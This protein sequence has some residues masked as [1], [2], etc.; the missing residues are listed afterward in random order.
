MRQYLIVPILVVMLLFAGCALPGSGNTQTPGQGCPSTNAPVCGS[1]GQTYTNSCLAQSAGVTVVHDGVCTAPNSAACSDG[2]G[3]K[4]IFTAGSVL[5]GGKYYDDTCKDTA[6]VKEYFCDNGTVSSAELPCPGGYAC[7]NGAC[8]VTPCTDTDGGAIAETKGTAS[9]SGTTQTDSCANATT[10]LEYYCSGGAVL[11]RQMDC[12][13][14]KQCT[15]GACIPFTCTDSDN[16]QTVETV[17]TTTYGTT[18]NTDSCADSSTVKEY[19]CEGGQMKNKNIACASGK[20]CQNGKCADI[21]CTE[22]DGGQSKNVAGNTTLGNVTRQDACYSETTVLEYYCQNGQIQNAQ[23]ACD[24]GKSCVNGACVTPQCVEKDTTLS[25][26]IWYQ[27][28]SAT[29]IKLYDGEKAEIDASTKKYYVGIDGISGD[30]ATVVLYDNQS[31]KICDEDIASG[32]SNDDLCSKGVSVQVTE[33]NENDSYAT[34]KGKVYVLEVSEQDGTSVAYT[35]TG[36]PA[37]VLDL[38]SETNKFYPRLDSSLN[39]K[40]IKLAGTSYK[41]VDV[42]VSGEL[43][44]LSIGGSDKDISDGDKITLNSVKYTFSLTFGDNGITEVDIEKS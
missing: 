2:D 10:V 31:D 18:S 7:T 23:L 29:S 43:L 28:K 21:V 26:D 5:S 40:S 16:G 39:T 37:T 38:N 11:S 41:V 12:G 30:T 3:G 42:D 13:T 27:I 17:G 33:V 24:S 4:D 34:I 15:D 9:A 36:C 19:Y 25:G 22:T 6:I 35:G 14:N 20:S 32:D 1:N 8:I 44:T